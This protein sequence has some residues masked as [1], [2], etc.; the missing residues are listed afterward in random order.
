MRAHAKALR[1][2]STNAERIVWRLIRAHRLNGVGFRRQVPIGHCIVNFVSH[3]V[4]LVIELDGGQHFDNADEAREAQRDRFRRS[5]GFRVLRINNC[6]VVTNIE[7]VWDV[8]AAAVGPAET[9]SPP[10]PASGGGLDRAPARDV[11]SSRA[12][13]ETWS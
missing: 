1:K 8:I 7:G 13:G 3:A 9:P 4:K 6:D 2:N 10:S 11:A 5:K 12:K